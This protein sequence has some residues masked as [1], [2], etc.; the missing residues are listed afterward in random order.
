MPLACTADKSS[1]PSQA[2]E[3]L[4]RVADTYICDCMTVCLIILGR[5]ELSVN[6]V[7]RCSRAGR[8]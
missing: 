6:T 3:S 1:Q 5:I 8:S 4:D 2:A 7:I